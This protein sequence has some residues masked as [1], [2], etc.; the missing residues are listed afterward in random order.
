MP[1]KTTFSGPLIGLKVVEIAGLGPTP[2]T[3]MLLADMG[4][5]VVR[6]ERPDAKQLIPQSVDFLNRGRGFVVL[7]LK[8]SDG[9]KQAQDLIEN[10]DVLIEGMRP[11]V[12]ERLGLGPDEFKFSNPKL[13]YGRMTGWGQY[14]PLAQSAG[15]DI[16]YIAL[17]GVLHAIGDSNNPIPP[18]NLV[19]DFGGGALYL[20]F[21]ILCAVLESRTSGKGQ[22]VDAAI[23]DGAAHLMTMMYSFL[24]SGIWQD[25]RASNLLDGA[26]P[27][28]TT[29]ECADGNFVAV[30]ALEPQF[31]AELLSRLG[32][33]DAGLPPQLSVD[34]W[35]QIRKA[36]CEAFSQ[37]SRDEWCAELEGTDAC[38]APVLTISEAKSHPH[39]KA[40]QT[41][42]KV[43]GIA[44][45]SAAPRFSRTPGKARPSQESEPLS[46]ET[47]LVYWRNAN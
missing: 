30:G 2:F 12:M 9:Q 5:E 31:Y 38:V 13:V 15:H 33:S 19:G 3:A 46:I 43:D 47:V 34:G 21:G 28:Y 16:N 39:N 45:P 6:I 4:A 35:P 22:V 11:G 29:Y 37:K 7:D 24:H 20:A 10:A 14:G 36:L 26:A 41:F 23:T 17:T 40:R 27:F 1:K 25:R 42:A 44:Q 18:L 8:S 32:L